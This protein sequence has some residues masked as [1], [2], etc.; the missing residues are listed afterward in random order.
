M[1]T[2]RE[3]REGKGKETRAELTYLAMPEQEGTIQL[4]AAVKYPKL[5]FCCIK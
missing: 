4:F 5:T 1:G 2:K 3:M